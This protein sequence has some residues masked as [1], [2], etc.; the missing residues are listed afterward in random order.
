MDAEVLTNYNK[1]SIS[2]NNLNH[3]HNMIMSNR[4]KYNISIQMQLIW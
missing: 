1:I 3:I 4:S 2:I